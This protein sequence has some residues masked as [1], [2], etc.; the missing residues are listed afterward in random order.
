MGASD[1]DM[2]ATAA[3]SPG[4]A[5][6]AV[7]RAGGVADRD[8]RA[9]SAAR[10]RAATLFVAAAL[11]LACAG[12]RP[13]PPPPPQRFELP[14]DGA[15]ELAVPR[16]WRTTV[17][18]ADPP[19]AMTVRLDP[20][21]RSF[22]VLVTPFVNAAVAG[23][24]AAGEGDAGA[25]TAQ[26]LAELARRKALVSSVEREIALEELRG[27]AGVHGYWF[28]ATDRALEGKE[29]GEDEWRHL[30]QGAAA[31]GELI[32]AFTLLDDGEGPQRATVLDL[33]R[34][35][36]HLP[37][38][39]EP[40]EGGGGAMRFEPDPDADTLPLSVSYP[41][42]PWAVLVDLPGFRMFAPRPAED[43][44]GV[45]VLGEDPESGLVASVT[46]RDAAG[47]ADARACR[48]RTLD[49]IRR[50]AP[51]LRE[52]RTSEADG[53]ARATFVLDDLRGRA[54]RQDHAHL[55]LH[56]DGVCVD[57][58]VSKADPEPGDAARMEKVFESV[59]FGETL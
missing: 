1:T 45:L 20:E 8:A 55:F 13:A 33:V 53:A 44:E 5:G 35:A 14:G 28:Q 36:R 38:V 40:P 41:G 22:V 31:V 59:R 56:R 32:V 3:R 6:G 52:L 19:A 57:V 43:G 30:L 27:E 37:R 26:V 11:A 18:E 34:G 2:S 48:E 49:R 9:P 23:A 54:V 47:A 21:D 51:E 25:D 50:S 24:P 16:G 39:G 17:G 46:M 12:R 42:R 4:R 58:Q 10:G 7:A 15:L 29:P